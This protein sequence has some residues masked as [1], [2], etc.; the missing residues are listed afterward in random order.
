MITIHTFANGHTT[1][2]SF[3]QMPWSLGVS[4]S[5]SVHVRH[6][7][8]LLLHASFQISSSSGVALTPDLG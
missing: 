3:V 2:G 5:Y 4:T 6:L 8:L 7:L 1:C